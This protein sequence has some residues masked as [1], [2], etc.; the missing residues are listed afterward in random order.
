MEDVSNTIPRARSALVWSLTTLGLYAAHHA[1]GAVRY[2]TPWR[3]HAAV[4]ALFV[5]LALLGAFFAFRRNPRSARGR[6][7]GWALAALVLVLPVLL[8]G[9]YE[10][11]YNHIVKDVLFFLGVPEALRLTLFPPPLYEMPNDLGFEVSGMLQGVPALF[12]GRAWIRFVG[13][14]AHAA[15]VPGGERTHGTT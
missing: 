9:V 5:A 3:H 2:A 4:V 6:V 8:I 7:A 1:Y 13:S 11:L 12:A 15:P 10:G 14:L